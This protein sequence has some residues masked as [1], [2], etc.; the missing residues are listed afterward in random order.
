MFVKAFCTNSR[1]RNE[2][3]LLAASE[4]NSFSKLSH[5]KNFHT[6]SNL[7]YWT[8]ENFSAEPYKLD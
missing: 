8:A 2:P 3:L 6:I 5:M 4:V 7:L 1:L